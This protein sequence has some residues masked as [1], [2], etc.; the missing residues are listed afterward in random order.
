M[1]YIKS[2]S[3]VREYLGEDGKKANGVDGSLI[4][5][6]CAILDTLKEYEIGT[7][8]IFYDA[9]YYGA[10]Q[11]FKTEIEKGN[12]KFSFSNNTY[13]C[14]GQVLCDFG[15]SQY[16]SLV[17]D[18]VFVMIVFHFGNP[19]F[20]DMSD[21]KFEPIVFKFE[22]GTSFYDILDQI[23][24]ESSLVPSMDVKIGDLN[25]IVIPRIAYDSYFVFCQET[26]EELYELEADIK[27]ILEQVNCTQYEENGQ[28]RNIKEKVLNK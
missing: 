20:R 3:R 26:G 21:K 28:Q 4:V 24:L 2:L 11:W 15:F 16:D 12:I 17:D 23:S 22:S 1:N 18:S 19:Y 7:P 25:C 5:P 10:E 14:N 8:D 9:T 6:I 27:E 13:D